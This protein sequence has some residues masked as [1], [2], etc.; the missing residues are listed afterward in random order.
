MATAYRFNKATGDIEA[1]PVKWDSGNAAWCPSDIGADGL[2]QMVLPGAERVTDATLAQRRASAPLKPKT[3]QR[4]CDAG[5]FSD[6][7]QQKE[8]FK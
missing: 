1:W 4:P 8:L 5:L 7:S 2:P 6:Q 3:D